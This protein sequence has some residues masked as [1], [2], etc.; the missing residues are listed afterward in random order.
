MRLCFVVDARSPIALNWIRYFSENGHHEVHIVSTY[1]SGPPSFPVTSFQLAP[2]ALSSFIKYRREVKMA[3][4]EASW[5]LFAIR[6]WLG[7]LDVNYRLS[8]LRRIVAGIKPDLIHAMRIPFEGILAAKAIAGSDIPI[9]ISVWGSDFTHVAAKF[10]LVSRLTQWA[11]RRI[12]AL[13]SDCERDVRLA[14]EWGFGPRKRSCVLPGGGGI[15]MDVFFQGSPPHALRE[16]LMIPNGHL[17]VINPRGSRAC[18]RNDSYFQA[19]PRILAKNPNIIFLSLAMAGSPTAERWVRRLGITRSVRLLPPVPRDKI[20]NLFRLADVSVS[21]SE[22][23]GTPN[24]LLEAMACGAFPVAGDIE[25][26]REW[27]QDGVNGILC[28]PGSPESLARAMLK[29]LNDPELRREAAGRNQK[30]IAERAEYGIVMRRAE[31][32]YGTLIGSSRPRGPA[33]VS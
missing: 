15:Q 16:E 10:P 33:V 1:P 5:Y 12:D 11:M 26:I 24:T 25:S 23:D 32:F 4:R 9:L 8:R 20:A 14:R 28:D 27:I 29:A 30:I 2:V 19:I 13:H 18:V 31:E 7:P 22:H 6:H 17:V 3:R 21:P